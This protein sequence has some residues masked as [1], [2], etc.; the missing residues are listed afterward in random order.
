MEYQILSRTPVPSPLPAEAVE[1]PVAVSPAPHRPKGARA[2][3]AIL[4]AMVLVFAGRLM[5]LTSTDL[6]PDEALYVW[7]SYTEPFAFSPHP[8]AVAFLARL[9]LAVTGWKEE[10]VRFFSFLLAALTPL[11]VFLLARDLAGRRVALWTVLA[12]V[13]VPLFAGFGAVMTPDAPQ[14][15]LWSLALWLTW[16]GLTTGRL[17]WWAAAGAVLG[18][19]LYVKYII[20]LFFPSLFLTLLLAPDLR[21]HLRRPGPWVA[22][23]IAFALFLPPAAASQASSGW[24]AL[25]YHLE[26]RQ[27]FTPPSA[28]S[29]AVYH[30]LHAV[31]L[32]PVIYALAL[33]GMF[34]AVR[35]GLRRQNSPLLFAGVFG[36]FTWLFFAAISLVTERELSREQWDAPAYVG[37]LIAAGMLLRD[38]GAFEPEAAGTRRRWWRLAVAAPVTGFVFFS[39]LALEGTTGRL[40]ALVGEE[41]LYSNFRGWS[42]MAR[43]TDRALAAMPA[44]ATPSI[45]LGNSFAEAHEFAFYTADPSRRIYTLDNSANERFGLV[46]VLARA[47]MNQ[48]GLARVTPGTNAVF[49]MITSVDSDG[50]VDLHKRE[51]K[52]KRIFTRVEALPD[53]ELS[54]GGRPV[55]RWRLYQCFGL[56][57]ERDWEKKK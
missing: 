11:P 4:A 47:G 41:M 38:R 6:F 45:F 16:R 25:K 35:A 39:V 27:S 26:D 17:G 3:Y 22:T 46:P 33:A 37:G 7:L 55:R 21:H 8:P 51:S 5:L 18:T 9:G 29:F 54:L 56:K 36:S 10:G 43:E 48:A 19:G 2:L 42:G 34:H 24:T 32:S 49:A 44:G 40:S 14:L 28:R 31:Y 52:L 23:A 50:G 53:G 13:S 1:P 15:F 20:V 30:G 12:F 57:P